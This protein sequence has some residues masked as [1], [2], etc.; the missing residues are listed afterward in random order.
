VTQRP[1]PEDALRTSET[2]E[3][4]ATVLTRVSDDLQALARRAQHLREE[5][6]D[7]RPL[8]DAMRAEA[9][10]LI[11]S[12]MTQLVDELVGAAL[13][14]RRAEAQQLRREGASQQQIA[15]IFGVSRQ[16]VAALLAE[17]D[18][19]ARGPHRPGPRPPR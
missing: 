11:I 15:D 16:R 13:A 5:L 4:L 3:R 14:V 2:L 12:R 17:P 7:G 19:R 10:P 6:A 18:P 9:R 1:L 8:T